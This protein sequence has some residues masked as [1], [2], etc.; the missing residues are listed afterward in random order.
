M[1]PYIHEVVQ[2]MDTKIVL[3]NKFAFYVWECMIR[4]MQMSRVRVRAAV[5]EIIMWKQ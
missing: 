1:K 3:I 2:D 4:G 5:A